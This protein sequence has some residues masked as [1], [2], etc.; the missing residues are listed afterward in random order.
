MQVTYYVK[1]SGSN[2]ASG[3][4]EAEALAGVSTAL[5][6]AN[7][8][9]RHSRIMIFPGTYQIAD[10]TIG[11]GKFELLVI[12]GTQAGSVI[13]ES[14]T[15]GNGLCAQEKHNVVLRKL[16]FKNG[17]GL[18]PL[19][20]G[21][22]WEPLSDNGNWL[23]EDCEFSNNAQR[24]LRLDGLKNLTMRNC[25]LDYNGYEGALMILVDS[26]FENCDFTRNHRLA[27]WSNKV[28]VAG[29]NIAADG[30]EFVNCKFNDNYKNGLQTDLEAES[31]TFVNCEFNRNPEEGAKFEI[32]R[33]PITFTGCRFDNNGNGIALET[34]WDAT[35]DHCSIQLNHET[36]IRLTWKNRWALHGDPNV[37]G[38]G[39]D[40]NLRVPAGSNWTYQTAI[41][42]TRRTILRNCVM[43]AT[44]SASLITK[45]SVDT[46]PDDYLKWYRDELD[47]DNNTYYH[48]TTTNAFQLKG[49]WTGGPFTDLAGWRAAT[50]EDASS[51][52]SADTSF[53]VTGCQDADRP[54]VPGGLAA[55]SAT[56]NSVALSWNAPA[57]SVTALKLYRTAGGATAALVA[58]L[59][60]SA[61]TFIDSGLAAGVAYTWSLEALAGM[62]ASASRASVSATT[63]PAAHGDVIVAINAG[64]PSYRAGDGTQFT[65]DA[66]FTGGQTVTHAGAKA[67]TQDDLLYETERYGSFGYGIA[68]A[69]G[70]YRVTLK[71]SEGYVSAAG[72]RTFGVQCEGAAVLTAFDVFAVAG[73]MNTAVDT[74]FVVAVSDG[75]LDLAWVAGVQEPMVN[76]VIVTKSSGVV[77]SG[78]EFAPIARPSGSRMRKAESF[79]LSGRRLVESRDM[80]RGVTIRVAYPQ[81]GA[82]AARAQR[83]DC[84]VR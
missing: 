2:A 7:A 15:S 35:F 71:F 61:R 6:K 12:E 58:S 18:Q 55:G 81:N 25:R 52:W 83:A 72:Q 49:D 40:G 45:R 63:L 4:S 50:G 30:V 54:A 75:S 46:S 78:N 51:R 17:T 14:K 36:G 3:T 70:T 20:L 1:P 22:E 65:A 11:G 43:S 24:G 62:C 19:F 57:S 66:Y 59:P 68:V 41:D 5:S 77:H 82:G 44:G 74:S 76:A 32:A 39:G 34:V 53:S 69:N 16:S 33:G 13:L 9:G 64:G 67:N 48:P 21:R 84:V 23:I 80:S 79:D 29:L 47:A 28:W 37:W 10:Q 38:D 27:G 31:F 56:K 42:G 26:R 60:S 8:D 73:A